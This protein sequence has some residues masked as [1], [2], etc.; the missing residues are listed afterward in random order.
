MPTVRF[1]DIWGFP[2]GGGGEGL[3]NPRLEGQHHSAWSGAAEGKI[4]IGIMEL[5]NV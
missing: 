5:C 3:I 2:L 4:K 1:G